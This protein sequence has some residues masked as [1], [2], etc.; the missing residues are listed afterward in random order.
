VRTKFGY[1]FL[2]LIFGLA[3]LCFAFV[4]TYANSIYYVGDWFALDLLVKSGLVKNTPSSPHISQA[5]IFSINE[6]NA[7]FWSYYLAWALSAC[8]IAS[9]LDAQSKSERTLLFSTGY[10]LAVAALVLL[11]LKLGLI[12]G[13][14][15]F[16]SV[17]FI[18]RKQ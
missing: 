15:S 6:A 9:V 18:R 4:A 11:N 12:L 14:I 8:S 3:S 16:I 5:S 2:S 7:I 10:V 13:A 17:M 1:G